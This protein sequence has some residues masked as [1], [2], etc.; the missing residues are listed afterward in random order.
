MFLPK[1][2]S[3]HYEFSLWTGYL[4]TLYPDVRQRTQLCWLAD[5]VA[6]KKTNTA[7][8]GHSPLV[9][10]QIVCV[11][12]YPPSFITYMY[13]NTINISA[14]LRH[15]LW[16]V[17]RAHCHRALIDK[18]DRVVI[19]ATQKPWLLANNGRH[20]FSSSFFTIISFTVTRD[21]LLLRLK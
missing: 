2:Q 16:Y 7:L 21:L 19:F 8:C 10:Q 11:D 13:T 15:H 14:I 12:C 9:W 5:I 4:W 20:F 6:D 1:N 3:S 18:L 17:T